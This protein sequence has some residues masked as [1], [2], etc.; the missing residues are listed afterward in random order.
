MDIYLKNNNSKSF[1]D[2]FR[3]M[4]HEKNTIKKKLTIVLKKLILHYSFVK[5]IIKF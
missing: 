4:M 2:N 3:K 1:I 5:D